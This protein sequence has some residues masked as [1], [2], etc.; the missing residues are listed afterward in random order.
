MDVPAAAKTLTE[1]VRD[2]VLTS[3][4]RKAVIVR[5]KFIGKE[6]INGIQAYHFTAGV[7]TKNAAAYCEVLVRKMTETELFRKLAAETEM[8]E[9]SKKNSIKI[10]IFNSI[11]WASFVFKICCTIYTCTHFF[12]KSK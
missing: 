9:E 5:K 10:W 3:D 1:T 2:H 11:I 12:G 4:T 8:N 7:D 6:Q